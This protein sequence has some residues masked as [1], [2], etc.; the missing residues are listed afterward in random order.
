MEFS[1][2]LLRPIRRLENFRFF[3]FPDRC[4]AH[5]PTPLTVQRIVFARVP[6]PRATKL[7]L[8]FLQPRVMLVGD[9]ACRRIVRAP[10]FFAL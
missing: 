1:R 7:E 5:Q 6:E 4:A 8:L 2:R 10:F 3:F 9:A